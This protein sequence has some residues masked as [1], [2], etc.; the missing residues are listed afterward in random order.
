[1]LLSWWTQ[2]GQGPRLSKSHWKRAKLSLYASGSE[3]QSLSLV[4]LPVL[5][6]DWATC[7]QSRNCSFLPHNGYSLRL[8]C[9][10]TPPP[11]QAIINMLRFL[12]GF[13]VV[14]ATSS[15]STLSTWPQL[16][17]VF[18][19][20]AVP[21]VSLSFLQPLTVP[22]Q[23]P[24]LWTVEHSKKQLFVCVHVIP[25]G[26]HLGPKPARPITSDSETPRVSVWI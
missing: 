14:G 16:F 13:A 15:E 6:N 8:L 5:M 23:V 22:S 1:M 12:V 24:R 21:S 4:Q 10:L 3:R 17:L 19:S 20:S 11:A 25:L 9:R 7:A 18:M 2:A 26:Q